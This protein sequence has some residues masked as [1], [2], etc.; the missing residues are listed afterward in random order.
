MRDRWLI[1]LSLIFVKFGLIAQNYKVSG[2][3]YDDGETLPGVIVSL[4][5]SDSVAIA[6]VITDGDGSFTVNVPPESKNVMV[7]VAL[8]GF[9]TE[10]KR[11]TVPCDEIIRFDLVP[12]AIALKEVHVVA[13]PI[14]AQ[15]DTIIYNV[16]SFKSDVDFSIEDV[17]KRMPGIQVQNNGGILYQGKPITKFYIEGLDMLQG[18][19]TIATRNISADDIATVDVYENHQPIRVLENIELSD[20]AALNLRLKNSSM[21]RP[22][23]RISAG[24]G[25]GD[26]GGLWLGELLSLLV[27]PEFQ[28]LVVG[29]TTNSG[30]VYSDEMTNHINA[31]MSRN[32]VAFNT[33]PDQLSSLPALARNRYDYN[34][35][36]IASVNGLKRIG[37]S[38]TV[39]VNAAYDGDR[40]DTWSQEEMRYYMPGGEVLGID[41][42]ISSAL[43][44]R[45]VKVGSEFKVNRKK[46]FV[47]DKLS[48]DG[49]FKF[50]N[51]GIRGTN[52][53]NQVLDV[54]QLNFSNSLEFV[55]RTGNKVLQFYSNLLYAKSPRGGIGI[56]PVGQDCSSF[57]QLTSGDMLYNNERTSLSWLVGSHVTLGTALSLNIV[58][59]KFWSETIPVMSDDG[60]LVGD[61]DVSFCNVST[62]L[63]PYFLWQNDKLYIKINTR[64][65]MNNMSVNNLGKSEKEHFDKFYPGA[66]ASVAYK[67]NTDVRMNLKCAYSNNSTG[68]LRNFITTPVYST[69]RMLNAM[70]VGRLGENKTVRVDGGMSYRDVIRMLFASI[71]ASASRTYFNMM[72]SLDVTGDWSQ[73]KYL[74]EDNHADNLELKFSSSKRIRPLNMTAKLDAAWT[75]SR[76]SVVRDGKTVSSDLSTTVIQGGLDGSWF[77]DGL[78]ASVNCSYTHSGQSIAGLNSNSAINQVR[79]SANLSALPVE[80]FV[81]FCRFDFRCNHLVGQDWTKQYF[82]D[83]GATYRR[84]RWELELRFNNLTG[85]KVFSYQQFNG[86]D[87]YTYTA[88]LRPF[89]ALAT[90]RMMY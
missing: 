10:A 12:E 61:N 85:Q 35:S 41:N 47:G 84:S 36:E 79:M 87:C 49:R 27:S 71:N 69:Y 37:E 90:V 38:A 81:L 9:R 77:S 5:S 16:A 78:V 68:A 13:K 64:L 39:S 43:R 21:L 33:F 19:Y 31:L 14:R 32:T 66:D 59:E 67:V 24:G 73:S 11:L 63:S 88:R 4:L 65:I 75:G 58:R 89:E 28:T 18:N 34:R 44:T 42:S 54:D 1:L 56:S 26:A 51:Y 72:S 83:A 23:G 82:L 76:S 60:A 62:M 29:K 80:N 3:V 7:K 52:D 40:A 53:V 2:V 86:P 48:F 8:L 17:L 70:G 55:V 6:R 50:G 20:K 30:A 74:Y 57:C 46:V 22:V 15:G 45:G 25:Y